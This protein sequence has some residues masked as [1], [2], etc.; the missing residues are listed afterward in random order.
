MALSAPSRRPSPADA[1]TRQLLALL[2]SLLVSG[3]LA[4]AALRL[5]GGGWLA[6]FGRAA[7]ELLATPAALGIV[8]CPLRSLTGIA[9]P[10]CGATRTCFALLRGDLAM[11]LAL[12]PFLVLA[13]AA[14]LAGGTAALVAPRSTEQWLAAAGRFA[15]SR[16]GR[17]LIATGLGFASAWQTAHLPG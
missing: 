6:A 11:A 4:L 9:C 14:L 16:R 15:R 8:A 1:G 7:D 12:N 2:S 3:Y 10:G 5:A 17:A 13:L